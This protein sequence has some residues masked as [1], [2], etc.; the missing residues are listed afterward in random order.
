MPKATPN[1]V[2]VGEFELNLDPGEL[3]GNG[4]TV[5]LGEKPFRILVTLIEHSGKLV[6][7]EELQ[8]RLWPND[9]FVDFEHGI[10]TAIKLLRKTL[11]DSVEVPRFIETIPR[12]GYRLPLPVEWINTAVIEMA[13]GAG[14]GPPSGLESAREQ[15]RTSVLAS[16]PEDFSDKK[17]QFGAPVAALKAKIDPGLRD[18]PAV[19]HQPTRQVKVFGAH[20]DIRNH[21]S[22][23][24]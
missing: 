21:H 1:R 8:R 15:P 5:C 9:T 24:P 23:Q 2:H 6:T 16:T 14:A 10:N 11:G 12:R 4:A 3:L 7:R 20:Q 18:A 19:Q 13:L 17:A 22:P